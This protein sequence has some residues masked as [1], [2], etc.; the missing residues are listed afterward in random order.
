VDGNPQGG[1]E[2]TLDGSPNTADRGGQAGGLRVSIQPPVD[3]VAEFKVVNTN[4][5]AQQGHT[6]GASVDV[7]VRSGTNQFHGTLYEFVRN[8]ALGANSFYLNRTAALGRDSDGKARQEARRY[9]RFGGTIG[10]PIWTPKLGPLPGYNGRDRSFFFFSHEQIRLSSPFSETYTLPIAAFR[11]GDFSSLLAGQFVYDPATARQ[12]GARVERQVISCN[13]RQNVI[14]DNRISPIAKAYLSFMPQPNITG[15]ENNFLGSYAERNDYKIYIARV[16]HQWSEKHRSFF[17]YSFSHRDEFDENTLGV[18][19]GVRLNGRFG[20]R[21]TRS[22]VFDHVWTGSASTILNLRVGYT[23]FRQ[24]RD[25]LTD[26]DTSPSKL[27]FAA[28]TISAFGTRTGIPRVRISNISDVVEQTGLVAV[29]RT[30][31]VQPTLTRTVGNHNMRMGY[32]FR[33][34]Q[35]NRT[36]VEYK[37][38]EIQ[39]GNN[40]TRLNDQNPSLP[41]NQIRAQ[42]LASFLLGIPT[43]GTYPNTPSVSNQSLYHGMFFQDDWKLTRKLT[44]NLGLRYELDTPTTERFNRNIRG[45]NPNA[46]TPVTVPGLSL[47]GGLE[48]VSA[49][50]RGFYEV[51]KNNFQPRIGFAYQLNEKTVM[52]GGFAVYTAPVTLDGINT[53]GFATSTPIDASP[54]LGL[55]FTASLADPYQRGVNQPTGAS[56]GLLTFLGQNIPAFTPV[57]RTHGQSQRYEISV[58]R[59]LPG[60]WVGEIAWIANRGYDLESAYDLN[61]V[62]EQFLSKSPVRDQAVIDN[63]TANV[64]NPFRGIEA[65]R[66]TTL[67]TA[68]T[69]QRQQ[70]VRPFPHFGSIIARRFDGSSW[71]NS[72]QTRLERRFSNGYTL[73]GTYTLSR[74]MEEIALLNPTDTKFERR[75]TGADSTHRIN[76]SGIYELPWGRGRKWGASWSGAKEALLGGFQLNGLYYYATGTPLTLGNVYYDGDITKL[77]L[78]INSATIGALGTDVVTDNVFQTSL[79]GLGFYFRDAAVQTNGALDW[80]KQRND[81]RINLANNLRTLP[82]RVGNLRNQPVSLVD[83]SLIK[84]FAFTETVKLQLRVEAINAF[85]RWQ[86][87]GPDLGPRNSTF[88][89][90][91]NSSA[92]HLPREYQLGLKLIF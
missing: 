41:V 55:T 19:N 48:F 1:N 62:P 5:D 49:D 67:F 14:C 40:F 13:G 91:T 59:E 18:N 11:T 69:I 50:Q 83:L 22:G 25:A 30:T 89:R 92:I 51:D 17:R 16:D 71:Y 21:G 45:F 76:L 43:A 53:T 10:G 60:K 46:T 73:L 36:P 74:G 4:F 75:L 24:T 7:S 3:S 58:Q 86:F 80:T 88:G 54:D 77:K 87:Q 38:G 2:F 42:A 44:L 33:V 39:F 79:T 63:L 61:P 57:N 32:D 68:A 29:P 81:P 8:D 84:N 78:N 35:E 12:N 34:Y 9:N 52:R 85:N 37:L 65:F 28:R 72:M 56:L 20:T 82:T 47:K 31:S 23:R 70:L 27:G 26:D 15:T 90:V 66:G 64:T 6:S